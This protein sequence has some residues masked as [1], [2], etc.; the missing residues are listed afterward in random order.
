MIFNLW[1]CVRGVAFAVVRGC[2]KLLKSHN[3][4]PVR[5]AVIVLRTIYPALLGAGGVVRSWTLSARL[6]SRGWP[7]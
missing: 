2:P 6:C 4:A 1:A 7:T 3:V 5:G